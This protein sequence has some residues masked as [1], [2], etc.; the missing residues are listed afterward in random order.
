MVVFPSIQFSLPACDGSWGS[1]RVPAVEVLIRAFA[2]VV[3]VNLDELA[4]TATQSVTDWVAVT[5]TVWSC[6]RFDALDVAGVAT[7]AAALALIAAFFAAFLAAFLA[8]FFAA[9]AFWMAWFAALFAALLMCFVVSRWAAMSVFGMIVLHARQRTE[10]DGTLLFFFPCF[11][12]AFVFVLVFVFVFCFVFCF[13]FCF[14]GAAGMAAT[15]AV[16]GSWRRGAASR[17]SVV[18]EPAAAAPLPLA[19]EFPIQYHDK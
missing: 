2:L 5:F 8:A 7:R 17:R 15:A 18:F 3:V 9:A 19:R 13:C 11:P 10:P 14:G 1:T 12:F 6:F 16:I 4:I